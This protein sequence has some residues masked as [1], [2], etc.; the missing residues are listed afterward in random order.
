[1]HSIDS[2]CQSCKL[3]LEKPMAEK[4]IMPRLLAWPLMRMTLPRLK[5]WR[6]SN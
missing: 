5:R 4:K 6:K 2:L 3:P 1:M